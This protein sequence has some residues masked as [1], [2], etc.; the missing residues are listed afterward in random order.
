M[1]NDLS[2]KGFAFN[3]LTDKADKDRMR[4]DLHYV[5]PAFTSDWCRGKCSPDT[6]LLEDYGLFE[7]T[8]LVHKEK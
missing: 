4:P 5:D 1:I 7:F 3:C 8:V 2:R 6:I